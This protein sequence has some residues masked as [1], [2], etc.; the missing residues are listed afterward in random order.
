MK[1]H[2]ALG[3]AFTALMIMAPAV[4]AQTPAPNA[5]G[6]GNEADIAQLYQL[7]AA[8][9]A[10]A[11]VHDPVNGDTQDV[12]D[13]RIKDMMALWTKDGSI[14]LMVGGPNDGNYIGT[15]DPSDATTCPAVSGT[16]G[17]TRGTLCTLFKYV[18][19][20]F[21]AK[22]KFISLA[23]SYLTSFTV[24]GDT[25]TVYFQCHYFNV[26]TDPW[27][28]ASHLVFNGAAA[29]VDG[30]WLFSHA[31]AP[32]TKD[33]PVPGQTPAPIASPAASLV[34]ANC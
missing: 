16:V 19:G 6:G 27:T 4:G 9:H 5:A 15:G 29:R 13:G 22:N 7:Q 26:A 31:D 33:I 2:L 1:K 23:P 21:Q 25:A 10:A 24:N 14:A 28:V 11:S 18:A 3:L 34:V 32:V 20:S 8:F 12:I 17:G 30:K